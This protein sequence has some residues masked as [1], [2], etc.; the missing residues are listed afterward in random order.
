[1]LHNHYHTSL[2]PGVAE[3][4]L[5]CEGLQSEIR[6]N[7]H[8][9]QERKCE[10]KKMRFKCDQ[11]LAHWKI[12]HSHLLILITALMNQSPFEVHLHC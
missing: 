1:M 4:R 6:H 5:E 9:I 12:R 7:M 11:S 10:R 2:S 8:L 3:E